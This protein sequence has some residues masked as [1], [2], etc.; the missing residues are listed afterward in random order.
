M[1]A[2][3][4]FPPGKIFPDRQNLPTRLGKYFHFSEK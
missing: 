4:D 2:G 1:F 3:R